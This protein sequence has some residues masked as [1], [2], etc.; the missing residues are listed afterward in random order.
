MRRYLGR[1]RRDRS[2][3]PVVRTAIDQEKPLAVANVDRLISRYKDRL[4]TLRG[5][6]IARTE[7]LAAL[8]ASRHEAYRQAIE[9]GDV[10]PQQ[11][12]KTWIATKDNRTRDSHREI[13][14]DTVGYNE[15]FRNGLLYPHE[16]NAPASET[17]NCRCRCNYRTDF[18]SNLT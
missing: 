17:A 4:L 5:E 2:F 13:D 14:R 8:N 16:P 15:R 18:V 7:S 12:R 3:D 6:T 9:K 11:I 10:T 1:A